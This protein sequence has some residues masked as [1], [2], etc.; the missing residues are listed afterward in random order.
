MGAGTV[1]STD[2]DSAR[3]APFPVPAGDAW[4]DGWPSR[5]RA[6]DGPAVQ[7]APAWDGFVAWLSEGSV[8]TVLWSLVIVSFAECL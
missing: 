5:D 7:D 1:G 2:V 4:G 8:L 3:V 6:V